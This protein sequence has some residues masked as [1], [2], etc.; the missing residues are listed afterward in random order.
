MRWMVRVEWVTEDGK[1]STLTLGTI[2]RA[3]GGT[4]TENVGVN[5]DLE[6]ARQIDGAIATN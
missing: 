4:V 6:P 5:R 2:D 1:R 3:G